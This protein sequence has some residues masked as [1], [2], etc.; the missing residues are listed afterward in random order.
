MKYNKKNI[1]QIEVVPLG[2]GDPFTCGSL[3]ELQE[4]TGI[5]RSSLYPKIDRGEREFPY[6]RRSGQ[7]YII[8]IHQL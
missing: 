3:T 2:G 1:T 5:H 4:R 8:K 7:Q 6:R